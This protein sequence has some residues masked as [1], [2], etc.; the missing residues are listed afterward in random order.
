VKATRNI[1]NPESKRLVVAFVNKFYAAYLLVAVLTTSHYLELSNL[2]NLISLFSTFCIRLHISS[3]AMEVN[4]LPDLAEMDE[5]L[6]TLCALIERETASL[7]ALTST[8]QT[9]LTTAV[10]KQSRNVN[11]VV[12]VVTK[13]VI[14]RSANRSDGWV[15]AVESAVSKVGRIDTLRQAG[16]STATING[17]EGVKS[18]DEMRAGLLKNSEAMKEVSLWT[19]VV[20]AEASENDVVSDSVSDPDL[21]ALPLRLRVFIEEKNKEIEALLAKYPPPSTEDV[22]GHKLVAL[23][24][25]WEVFYSKVIS[26]VL[27]DLKRNA[28]GL[29]LVCSPVLDADGWSMDACGDDPKDG[30]E[31]DH[32]MTSPT[33]P[34]RKSSSRSNLITVLLK[35]CKF[36]A[37]QVLRKAYLGLPP[38]RNRFHPST[39][40]RSHPYVP[41]LPHLYTYRP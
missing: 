21:V 25:S 27:G 35:T 31:F 9:D 17:S 12:E 34:K 20:L 16:Q 18:V 29:L 10:N 32:S 13:G 40:P 33:E 30:D 37:A 2:H 38:L 6:G 14:D 41:T 7:T 24:K 11:N 8:L 4:M 22:R 1:V 5:D 3:G 28:K 15:D 26:Q 23:M 19:R 36:A 39:R